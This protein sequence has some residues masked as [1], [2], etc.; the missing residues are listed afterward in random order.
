MKRLSRMS[1]AGSRALLTVLSLGFIW[2]GPAENQDDVNEVVAEARERLQATSE[3]LPDFLCR[4][5]VVLSVWRS[6]ARYTRVAAGTFEFRYSRQFGE[7]RV[8]KTEEDKR[9]LPRVRILGGVFSTL[10]S[11]FGVG[12]S[13]RRE[14]QGERKGSAYW[15]TFDIP[16][17]ESELVLLQGEKKWPLGYQGKVKVDAESYQPLRMEWKVTTEADSMRQARHKLTYHAVRF[18][19]SI[20]YLPKQQEL[21]LQFGSLWYKAKHTY[22]ECRR[23]TVRIP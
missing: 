13:F 11:T 15:L 21:L 1:G 4:E 14:F 17:E 8:P 18:Q 10:Y 20:Y 12:E 5:K 3:N 9:M 2:A 22:D 7:E 6:H 23:F 19:D 16:V